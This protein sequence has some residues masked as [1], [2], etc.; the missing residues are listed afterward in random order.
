MDFDP[1]GEWKSREIV[2]SP[3]PQSGLSAFGKRLNL[4]FVLTFVPLP[5]GCLDDAFSLYTDASRFSDMR[6]FY[7]ILWTNEDIELESSL[8]NRRPPSKMPDQLRHNHACT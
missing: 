8:E 4:T 6:L 2:K 7:A 3:D 1:K 5:P